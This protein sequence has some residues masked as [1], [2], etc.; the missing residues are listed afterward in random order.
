M[1]D[2]EREPMRVKILG[3]STN[4]NRF[5]YTVFFYIHSSAFTGSRRDRDFFWTTRSLEISNKALMK[6]NKNQ[7]LKNLQK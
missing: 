4:E 7:I 3:A 5:F 6:E 2:Q 1:H